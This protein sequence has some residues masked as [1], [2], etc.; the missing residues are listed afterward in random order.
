ME[1]CNGM[2]LTSQFSYAQ[3]KQKQNKNPTQIPALIIDTLISFEV[4]KSNELKDLEPV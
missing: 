2:R 1:V 4:Y 3:K